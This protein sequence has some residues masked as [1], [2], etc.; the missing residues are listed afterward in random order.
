[1]ASFPVASCTNF[2]T[3]SEKEVAAHNAASKRKTCAYNLAKK[4]AK[5]KKAPRKT[6]KPARKPTPTPTSRRI[7]VKLV[8]NRWQANIRYDKKSHYLGT[9]GSEEE[10]AGVYAE[11]R[12]KH[13]RQSPG[14]KDNKTG[15]KGVKAVTRGNIGG[16]QAAIHHGGK[17]IYLGTYDRKEDAAVAFNNAASKRKTC[18]SSSAHNNNNSSSKKGKTANQPA[19]K[20][21]AT[22]I[23][24]VAQRSNTH[25]GPL[26]KTRNN[27][28]TKTATPA[29]QNHI[30]PATHQQQQQQPPPAEG[31]QNESPNQPKA[32]AGL[33]RL[34]P[35]N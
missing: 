1:M 31:V 12:R 34:P 21:M 11:A 30:T 2:G 16:Y 19:K 25:I 10:A 9:Y 15:F 27:S 20:L 8:G 3:F 33:V 26:P 13:P 4:P 29:K 35:H 23:G 22:Y 14:R 28:K 17:Q 18:L 24:D 7:G 5:K 32:N 6:N